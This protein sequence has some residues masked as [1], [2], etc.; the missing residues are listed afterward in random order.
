M[1]AIYY[2]VM[3]LCTGREG[4]I[5]ERRPVAYA[6]QVE[7]LDTLEAMPE[8]RGVK[9][10]CHRGPQTVISSDLR[11]KPQPHLATTATAP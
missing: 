7:C 9:Y 8:R 6:S 3:T 5:D 4:C 10:R 11:A 1:M 2:I